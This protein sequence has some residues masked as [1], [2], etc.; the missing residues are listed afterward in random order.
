MTFHHTCV[1]III[2][3]PTLKKLVGYIAFGAC[4][5]AGGGG[6]G[7]GS[8]ILL[9]LK[10]L[11]IIHL[12]KIFC[13]FIENNFIIHKNWISYNTSII[14]Y[15]YPAVVPYSDHLIFLEM[16]GGGLFFPHACQKKNRL[17]FNSLE[18]G[19]T[20]LRTKRKHFL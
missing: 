5:C 17:F 15:L 2:V 20:F 6:G 8:V 11:H 18:A 10:E 1:N 16:G 13:L 9:S 3:P 12:I 19:I 7:W 4:V 14:E